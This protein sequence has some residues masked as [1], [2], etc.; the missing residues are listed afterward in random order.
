VQVID[1]ARKIYVAKLGLRVRGNAGFENEM[2]AHRLEQQIRLLIKLPQ[3]AAGFSFEAPAPI[4]T[5]LSGTGPGVA[6][7]KVWGLP[8]AY[9]LLE[10]LAQAVDAE[11]TQEAALELFEKLRLRDVF[12]KAFT[13][14]GLK[15]EDGWRAA[16]RIRLLFL[17][18]CKSTE[19][20]AD[21]VPPDNQEP[22]TIFGFSRKIWEDPDFRWLI[23]LHD[24]AGKQYFVQE[25]HEELLWCCQLPC[26][27]ELTQTANQQELLQSLKSKLE[28]A[29][30]EARIA[31]YEFEP[32]TSRRKVGED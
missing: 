28:D 4:R 5:L 20:V 25:S 6:N 27:L 29:T 26:L 14:L 2:I 32:A 18:G 13:A 23:G 3:L 15:T 7:T 10:G 16:A 17:S 31:K 30:T 8:V 12:A 19:K 21:A 1:E 24:D 11:H 22:E 9:L